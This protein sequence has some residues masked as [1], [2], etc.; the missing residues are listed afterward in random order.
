MANTRR[1]PDATQPFPR[2]GLMRQ[3]P[4]QS[5]T[6]YLDAL[7]AYADRSPGRFHVPGH[8]GGA[9]AAPEIRDAFGERAP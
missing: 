2:L 1:S 8:K 6:P 9:A 5:A 3:D 7:R 4:S